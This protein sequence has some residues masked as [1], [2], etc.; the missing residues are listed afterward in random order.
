MTAQYIIHVLKVWCHYVFLGNLCKWIVPLSLYS[1]VG[2]FLLF[3]YTFLLGESVFIV[4]ARYIIHLLK[5]QCHC[6]SPWQVMQMK[7]VYFSV[8]A[9]FQSYGDFCRFPVHFVLG[10]F[11]F[12][13]TALYAMY[14]EEIWCHYVSLGKFYKRNVWIVPESRRE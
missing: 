2:Q 10:E 6:V 12:D 1:R 8:I 11:V 5:V 14:L 3:S 9:L 7:R 4:T 13:V